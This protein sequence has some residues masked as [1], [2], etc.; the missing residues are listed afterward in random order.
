MKKFCVIAL[1][2]AFAGVA[3]AADLKDRMEFPAKNG[4]VVFYHNNHV[5]EVRG[6]CKACHE[7]APGRIAGFGKDYAHKICIDCHKDPSRPEGPT[8]CD[9]CH[10]K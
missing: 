8:K 1:L 6:D 2:V 5:N 10:K 7:K 3:S 9:G 4:N